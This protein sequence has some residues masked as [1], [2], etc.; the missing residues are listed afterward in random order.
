MNEPSDKLFTARLVDMVALCERD[1]AAVFSSFF[2]DRQCAEAEAWCARNTGGLRYRLWGGYDDARRK[3]LAVYPDYC[4]DYVEREYPFVC[5]TFTYRKEDK[6]THRDFLGSFRGLQL[7]REII[8]DI[9]VSEGIT[10]V[11]V[12]EV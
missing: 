12:T 1:G 9:V 2:D 4:E 11:F 7:K 8:G 5:L 10:Q 3:M 6:L